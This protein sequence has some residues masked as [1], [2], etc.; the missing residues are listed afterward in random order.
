MNQITL[1]TLPEATPEQVFEQIARHM[2]KQWRKSTALGS[3][4]CAYRGAQG[5]TCAAG[6]L[7]SD[8]E[9]DPRWEARSWTSLAMSQE[10]PA[11]YSTLIRRLQVI[12]D[13]REVREWPGALLDAARAYNIEL[14]PELRDR[15]NSY[16]A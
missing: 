4:R 13:S 1:A 12:H 16:G 9:Y 2:L 15:L 6:C 10:V 5:L 11:D 8:D 7:I 14:S 3:N